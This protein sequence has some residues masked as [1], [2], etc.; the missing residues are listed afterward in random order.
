MSLAAIDAST[1]I[2]ENRSPHRLAVL[3]ALMYTNRLSTALLSLVAAFVLTLPAA[4]QATE[5]EDATRLQRSGRAG[6]ALVRA[7][8]ALAA[9]PKD[10]PLRFLRGV[11]LMELGR[12]DQALDAFAAMTQEYPDLAE[13]YNN[14]GVLRSMR[15]EYDQARLAFEAAVRSSPHSA[16]AQENLGDIYAVLAGQAYARAMLIEPANATASRKLALIRQ[17][18]PGGTPAGAQA[19]PSSIPAAMPGP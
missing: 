12:H 10:A 4:T 9:N 3:F 11:L 15:G 14:L 17:M 6:E 18:L 19:H 1:V 5:L 13:P 7:D 2:S 16:I 8:A